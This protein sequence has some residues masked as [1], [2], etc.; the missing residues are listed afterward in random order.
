LVESLTIRNILQ[1]PYFQGS[2]IYA[3]E[4]ALN[5]I[6]D[7]VHILE[8]THVGHLLNGNELILTTGLVWKDHE[9]MGISFLQ[10]IMDCHASGLCIELG[11]V[12]DHIP[13]SMKRLAEDS[14]FP[15]I[16]IYHN[17]HHIRYID[18]TRDLHSWII[19]QQ[20]QKVN[21]FEALTVRFN[22]LLLSGNGLQSLLHLYY[23]AT[24]KPI[25]YLPIE[26]K[27]LFVPPLPANAQQKI[28]SW[29]LN[30]QEQLSRSIV[31]QPI[32]V[33]KQNLGELISWSDEQLNQFDMLALDRC[34]TAVAQELM[35][36]FYWEERRLYKQNQ[37]I[38]EWLNGRYEE[39][40]IR[41]YILSLKPTYTSGQHTVVIFE[42]DQTMMRSTEFDTL[43]FQRNMVARSI[44]EQEGFFLIPTMMNGHMIYILLDLHKRAEINTHLTRALSGI[45]QADMQNASLFSKYIGVGRSFYE[46]VSVKESLQ[47]A[48]ETISIQKE[49][50][51]LHQP[52]YNELHI[53]RV[54]Y[55]FKKSGELTKLVQDYIGPII[56]LEKEKRE[57]LLKT[58][59][60][61]FIFNGAK[62]EAAKDLYISRQTLYSR[63]EK[64][65]EL[66]GNDFTHP[67]KSFVI[68]LAVYAYDYLA[69]MEQR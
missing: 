8:V 34:A 3:S 10:Q 38:H 4:K 40:E 20:R 37:W 11:R 12:I 43:Y 26:D 67:K 65:T 29:R 19:N 54:L 9:E 13:E 7:W 16:L 32:V 42:L 25:A 60:A 61:Y 24:K 28:R 27:P 41:P 52:F 62:R 48:M 58:L 17:I 36:T 64:I 14:D 68:E 22:E 1:R 6:V 35:R 18:I 46:L 21:E 2:T 5:N 55:T 23:E 15:L 66:L 50:G 39:K 56:D 63:L 30:P 31:S 47:T 59:K 33:L 44:F 53:Y 57:Q 69:L 45:S 49:I 51:L